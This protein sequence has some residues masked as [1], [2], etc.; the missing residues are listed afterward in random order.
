[1]SR[2]QTY[3]ITRSRLYR[4]PSKRRLADALGLTVQDLSILID[5]SNYRV[6][7]TM[8]SGKPRPVQEPMG[9]LRKAHDQVQK[10]LS[11]IEPREYLLS[12]RK[13]YSIF[14][15]AEI[16]RANPHCA[17]IDVTKFFAS[18]SKNAVLQFF[19][20]EL[21]MP[22]DVARVLAEICTFNGHIPTGS[23]LSMNIAFWAYRPTFDRI[24]SLA[25][26]EGLAFS[27]W[28]DDLVFS[29]QRP[30]PF[31][32]LLKIKG[33]LKRAGLKWNRKKIARYGK[34]D[35]KLIT[36]IAVSP[37]ARL[38]APNK[39]R[40][41]IVEILGQSDDFR[42]LEGRAARSLLGKLY[43][44]RRI[45]PGLFERTYQALRARQTN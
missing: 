43:S 4:L 39:Q 12:G 11:R 38:Q 3:P 37:D 6:G 35:F 29:G 23:P 42:S 13:G 8:K 10:Y 30:I 27:L 36:G 26:G 16:H 34:D 20:F 1:M 28:V 24:K 14:D 9:N 25:Q 22:P 32:F 7:V 45:Q 18:S 19:L 2:L 33:E 15:N 17:K 31:D 40:E 41:S 21:Q 5:D 44:A